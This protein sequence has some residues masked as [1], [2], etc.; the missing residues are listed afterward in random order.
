M[1][2]LELTAVLTP[3]VAA[4]NFDFSPSLKAWELLSIV[5]KMSP[6]KPDLGM[7][8]LYILS[9]FYDIISSSTCSLNLSRFG[10]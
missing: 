10:K 4:E 8:C 3:E 1:V 5:F 2:L 6:F 9:V 7:V